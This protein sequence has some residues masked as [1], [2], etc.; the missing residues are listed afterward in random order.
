MH[1]LAI[2]S[3]RKSGVEHVVYSSLAFAGR[4]SQSTTVAQVML[5]HLQTEQ[6]LASLHQSDPSFS[7]SVIRQGLYSES[8]P[9]YTAFF[10]LTSPPA[11]GLIKIPH[12]GSG[13]GIAWAKRDELGEATAKLLHR[14]FASP[15]NFSPFLDTVT[16]LSGP[17]DYFMNE[18]AA[19]LGK[20][21][22]REIKIQQVSVEEY[23]QQPQVREGLTYG[24]GEWAALWATAFEGIRQGE[25]ANPSGLLEELLGREPES[26]EQT[27]RGMTAE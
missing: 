14:A 5:A 13:P 15:D 3:A 22:G 12:D 8:F 16:L 19:I 24:S 20:V 26:F 4:P 6:Y 11:D 2:D 10:N 27:V 23:A 25:T 9:I 7:Y 17:R 21:A 1:K 18:T